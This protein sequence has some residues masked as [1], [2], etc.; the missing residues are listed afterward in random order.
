MV[1]RVLEDIPAKAVAMETGFGIDTFYKA[2]RGE[3]KLPK[4]RA[5][6]RKFSGL[7]L[8]AGLAVAHEDTGWGMFGY[9][10]GDR[11]IQTLIQICL[12]EDSEVDE[13]LAGLARLLIGKT[14]P[15]DLTSEDVVTLKAVVK[16][17]SD[18]IKSHLNFIIGLDEHYRLDVIH[19]IKKEKNDPRAQAKGRI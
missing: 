13:H 10:E 12:K 7:H 16:E 11:H 14:Q 15:E 18:E 8:C 3:R 17:V 9:I 1:K 19:W 2:S 5:A 6:R 4:N